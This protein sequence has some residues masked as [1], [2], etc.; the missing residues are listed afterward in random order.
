MPDA[1]SPKSL[2]VVLNTTD[3]SGVSIKTSFAFNDS[4]LML[5]EL[6]GV[7]L[8]IAS[9]VFEYLAIVAEPSPLLSATEPSLLMFAT[10]TILSVLSAPT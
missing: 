9:F 4:N 8:L 5:C 3:S 10:L 1:A 6:S 7:T 2:L